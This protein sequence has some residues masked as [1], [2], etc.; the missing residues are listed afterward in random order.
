MYS[1]V[2]G[3]AVEQLH[4]YIDMWRKTHTQA[5]MLDE[6]EFNRFL[7]EI[8]CSYP[9]WDWCPK[10]K[11]TAHTDWLPKLWPHYADR[12]SLQDLDLSADS[13]IRFVYECQKHG[14]FQQSLPTSLSWQKETS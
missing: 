6:E 8:I 9:F 10:C 1:V 13:E 5:S 3:R 7:H 11:H 2:R 4:H 14:H 12:Q